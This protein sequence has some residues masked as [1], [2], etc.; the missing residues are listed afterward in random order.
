[1]AVITERAVLQR[2]NRRLAHAAQHFGLALGVGSQRA[3][4]RHP[5]LLSTYTVAREA[6]PEAYR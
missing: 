6:A 3:A 5:E 1:M 2:I 4:I